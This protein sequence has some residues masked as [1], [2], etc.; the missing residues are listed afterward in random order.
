MSCYNEG[1]AQVNPE[2]A[3][4]P[5]DMVL[6]NLSAGPTPHPRVNPGGV[7]GIVTATAVQGLVRVRLQ[8]G[9]VVSVR[10][11]QIAPTIH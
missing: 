1:M 7:R 4:R 3:L 2:Q 5:G 10:R 9:N 11:D 6:V 8:D